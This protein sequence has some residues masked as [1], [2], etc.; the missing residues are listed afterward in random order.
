MDLNFDWAITDYMKLRFTANNLTDERR[1]R[2]W[3]TPLNWYSDER[4]NGQE[5]VL[6]L[7]FATR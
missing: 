2:Y 4:D 1:T 3:D 7:R 6:E 5:Y